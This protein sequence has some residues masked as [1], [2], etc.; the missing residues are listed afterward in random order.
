MSPYSLPFG[1]DVVLA[2]EVIFIT[3]RIE[4]FTSET[5]EAGLKEKLD[6]LEERKAKAHIKTLHY[7]RAIAR[8]Y[9]RRIQ[10][11]PIGM[12]DLVLRKVE[13]NA[14]TSTTTSTLAVDGIV[15]PLPTLS[16]DFIFPRF[17]ISTQ[18]KQDG[19]AIRALAVPKLPGTP[20]PD[21]ETIAT[22][23]ESPEGQ[24]KTLDLWVKILIER[25]SER[26]GERHPTYSKD[27]QE[28]KTGM[29]VNNV[30]VVGVGDDKKQ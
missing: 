5:S 14:L 28:K 22:N 2:P 25:D 13:V 17:N 3:L 26:G 24:L 6:M 20:T 9:N 16:L 4:N 7:E 30:D 10:P 11:R 29:K 19:I 8:L 18:R 15:N 21:D 23:L 1:I 27:R 12:R